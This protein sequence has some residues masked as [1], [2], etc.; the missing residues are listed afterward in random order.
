MMILLTARSLWLALIVL[1]H[2][3]DHVLSVILFLII[4]TIQSDYEKL[5]FRSSGLISI[6]INGRWYM[7]LSSEK[8]GGL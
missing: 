2:N 1:S 5:Y 4:N 3:V 7:E 8:L 6:I